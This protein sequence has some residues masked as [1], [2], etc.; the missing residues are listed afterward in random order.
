MDI[1]KFVYGFDLFNAE[2]SIP[3]IEVVS[4]RKAHEVRLPI[5]DHSHPRCIEI[6]VIL[7]GRE[8]FIIEEKQYDLVGNEVF[9]AYPNQNH[10]SG[11]PFQGIN[12]LICISMNMEEREGFLGLDEPFSSILF[13]KLSSLSEHKLQCDEQTTNL[14]K[15]FVGKLLLGESTYAQSL[16]VFFIHKLLSFPAN[17]D[18]NHTLDRV[19]EFIKRNICESLTIADIC[20]YCRVSRSLLDHGFRK[21][22]GKTVLNYINTL[23]M[24]K[25][26]ELLAS[27]MT[28]TETAQTLSFNSSDYFSVVFKRYVGVSPSKLTQNKG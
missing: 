26:K 2:I 1:Y 23:K 28:V 24:E 9:L 10:R 22:T 18:S 19:I 27:G 16:F 11:I 13:D 20:K 8:S 21:Y 17:I 3:A 12:E 6:V 4:Y 7:K 5:Y 25:A 15:D 14:I